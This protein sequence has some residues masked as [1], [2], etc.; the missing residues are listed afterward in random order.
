MHSH[1]SY[2][3]K[4]IMTQ[5]EWQRVSRRIL[6]STL[7]NR[8]KKQI[9]HDIVKAVSFPTPLRYVKGHYARIFPL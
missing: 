7:S 9:L 5:N 6:C 1:F 8:L 3:K 2:L 4:L